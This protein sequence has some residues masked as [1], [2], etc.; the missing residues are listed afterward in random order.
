MKFDNGN[1]GTG[2]TLLGP[3]KAGPKKKLC[4]LNSLDFG[5]MCSSTLYKC[6]AVPYPDE[7]VVDEGP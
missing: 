4:A 6:K 3:P 2:L 1:H 5:S 7:V